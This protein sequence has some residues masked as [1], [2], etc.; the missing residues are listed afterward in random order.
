MSV[1]KF[2]RS[3]ILKL[4]T[5][6]NEYLEIAYPF[7]LE[8][9]VVRNNLAATNTATFNLI[10]LNATTRSKIY[11]DVWDIKN[12]KSVQLFAGYAESST[13]LLP[14]IFNGTVKR[15]YSQ[16]QGPDFRTMIEAFDGQISLGSKETSITI[17]AGVTSEQALIAAAEPLKNGANTVTVG[18]NYKDMAQRAR[19]MMGN[20]LEILNQISGGG[21]YVDNGSVYVLDQTEVVPGEIRLINKDNGLLGTPKKSEMMVELEM[22]FE[23]RLRPSQLIELQSITEDRFD[24]LYKV[25]G[26]T[27]RGT[28]SGAIGGDCRTTLQLMRIKGYEVVM[29]QSTL[30]YR[31]QPEA[32]PQ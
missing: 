21:A 11:H 29:D 31:V 20:P 28:I 24:G 10:N 17:P 6:D 5:A 4:E 27:H 19:S 16:R 7:T 18:N 3:Y 22:L 23:P 8:F 12:M 9:N 14:R 26:I 32:T 15:A 2:N 25:T 30:E 1:R 13:D